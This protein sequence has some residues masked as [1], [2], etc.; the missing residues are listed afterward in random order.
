MRLWQMALAGFVAVP[1]LSWWVEAI[2][3][4]I[5]VRRYRKEEQS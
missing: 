5:R 4:H 1:I 2:E 3:I